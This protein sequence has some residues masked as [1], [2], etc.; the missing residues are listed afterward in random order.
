MQERASLVSE[1]PEAFAGRVH[2]THDGL[3][4][5]GS[6]GAECELVVVARLLTRSAPKDGI[7][8][9][10]P[11]N[12]SRI[13][14]R[15]DA[16]CCHVNSRKN[17]FPRGRRVIVL[18]VDRGTNRLRGPIAIR[19]P[20][21]RATKQFTKLWT[22]RVLRWN[23]AAGNHRRDRGV[24]IRQVGAV[25]GCDEPQTGSRGFDHRIVPAFP[26]RKT[27]VVSG[28]RIETGHLGFSHNATNK[29]DG[30]GIRQALTETPFQI[31]EVT[32]ETFPD[33]EP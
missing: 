14:V 5:W 25:R 23:L 28:R 24:E 12:S 9:R 1:S 15:R 30:C 21:V 22:I 19:F 6:S 27:D 29:C 17:A 10:R 8:A 11:S 26:E 13:A 31:D 2:S 3:G 7:F 33:P 4:S 20:P 16:A 32:Q 18:A